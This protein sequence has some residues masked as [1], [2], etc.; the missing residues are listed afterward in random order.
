MDFIASL[1]LGRASVFTPVLECVLVKVEL[2]YVLGSAS[3][4]ESAMLWPPL[5]SLA[6]EPPG[7]VVAV[8]WVE[9]LSCEIQ[10]LTQFL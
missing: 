6:L 9:A 10:G 1:Y 2:S 5:L 3:D 8:G 7:L 4:V